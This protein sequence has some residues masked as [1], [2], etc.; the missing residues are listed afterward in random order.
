MPCRIIHLEL[1][2]EFLGCIRDPHGLKISITDKEGNEVLS[3]PPYPIEN[4][5]D[6]KINRI[7]MNTKSIKGQIGGEGKDDNVSELEKLNNSP[8]IKEFS[9]KNR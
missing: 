1:H 3:S 9:S 8:A 6:E 2:D 7:K 4:I 5:E